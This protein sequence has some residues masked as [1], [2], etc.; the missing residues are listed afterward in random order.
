[1]VIII[2]NEVVSDFII[3]RGLGFRDVG[4]DLLV[5]IA[6]PTFIGVIY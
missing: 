5:R 2:K 1:M 4:V 3:M 6:S